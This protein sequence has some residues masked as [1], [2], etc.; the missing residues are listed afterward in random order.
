MMGGTVAATDTASQ[1]T[2]SDHKT[3]LASLLGRDRLARLVVVGSFLTIFLLVAALL[4]L[5]QSGS[6][7][8]SEAAKSAFNAI[9]PVLAG[10]VGTVLAYYFS[11]ASQERTSQ[12]LDK[13]IN[14]AGDGTD[15]ASPVSEKMTPL[16]SIVGLQK[17]EDTKPSA[18]SIADL[19]KAFEK[20]LPNGAKVTRLLFTEKGIF[21]Y[22]VHG[23][24]LNAFIV[25]NPG[26][27]AADSK[28][29]FADM[30]ADEATLRQISKLVVFVA[31]DATLADAKAALDKVNGAQDIIVTGSGNATDPMLGWLSNVDLI[32]ALTN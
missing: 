9:L 24:E 6:Q 21:R 23:S 11:A 22:V 26:A 20:T 5:A 14:K 10:W 12:S 4:G 19:Q 27:V 1:T 2:T 28:M 30:L 25:K 18:I 31:A 7:P 16:S 32:K 29:S 17:L 13:A 3:T 8:A 15:P